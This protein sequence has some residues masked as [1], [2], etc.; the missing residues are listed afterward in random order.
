MFGLRSVGLKN[1]TVNGPCNTGV[2]CAQPS[3]NS[4]CGVVTHE[5]PL[6]ADGSQIAGDVARFS[7][8]G[9]IIFQLFSNQPNG[10]DNVFINEPPVM[11]LDP[12]PILGDVDQDGTPSC[13]TQGQSCA[14]DPGDL[15]AACGFPTPFP[16]CDASKKVKVLPDGIASAADVAGNRHCDLPPGTY[17]DLD[18]QNDAAHLR[19]RDVHVLPVRLRQGH[20][21][22]RRERHRD[23]RAR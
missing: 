13:R 5:N 10:L 8:G 22:A 19:G 15:E 14:V 12:L 9:G 6:Y 20:R 18:V 1:I 21:D 17:G 16:A 2:N 11:A 3:T 4:A 23:Q 7:K